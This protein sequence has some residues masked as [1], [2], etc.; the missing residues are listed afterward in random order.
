MPG[1]KGDFS[2]CPPRPAKRVSVHSVVDDAN[3]PSR[4]PYN[5]CHPWMNVGPQ[6]P[7]HLS[8]LRVLH[9]EERGGER[10]REGNGGGVGGPFGY[11]GDDFRAD[12]DVP[13]R[14]PV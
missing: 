11:G 10:L 5:P 8:D 14:R 7:H 2:N 4:N 13:N 12:A 9:A 3:Q 1:P 6:Q